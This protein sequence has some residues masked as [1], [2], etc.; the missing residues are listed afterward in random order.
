MNGKDLRCLSKILR[1]INYFL[2]VVW[3]E[4]DPVGYARSRGVRIGADCHLRGATKDTFGSE[5]YLIKIGDRVSITHDVDFIT[6]DG[7]IRQFRSSEPD[8][9]VLGTIV[10]GNDV[11]IGAHAILLPD[12]VIG[13]GCVIGVG[14]V[15]KGHF[16]PHSLIL[17]NPARRI[18]S[19][20][21]YWESLKGKTLPTFLLEPTAKRKYLENYFWKDEEKI[22]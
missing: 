13:D 6:H 12:T 1:I 20:K 9:D 19:T 2:R 22:K 7:G 8:I 21:D 5:P 18:R 11:V 14:S 3:V 16:A 17:G 15:V 10:I 4:L